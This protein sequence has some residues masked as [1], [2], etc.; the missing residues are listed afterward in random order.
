MFHKRP[1]YTC[2]LQYIYCIHRQYTFSLTSVRT[3]ACKII[4]NIKDTQFRYNDINGI[5]VCERTHN[6]SV[7]DFRVLLFLSYRRVDESSA[8]S[9]NVLVRQLLFVRVVLPLKQGKLKA[10]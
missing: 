5:T 1:M 9:Y 7:I 8:P 2:V 6:D 4:P 3:I 10:K